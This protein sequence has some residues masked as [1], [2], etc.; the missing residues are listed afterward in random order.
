MDLDL[1]DITFHRYACAAWAQPGE[2]HAEDCDCGAVP[3]TSVS[4]H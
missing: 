2:F 4:E 1:V 3:T